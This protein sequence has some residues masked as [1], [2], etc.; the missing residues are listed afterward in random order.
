M[1]QSMR[2]IPSTF[3][4]QILQKAR[5]KRFHL[6]SCKLESHASL[7]PQSKWGKRWQLLLLLLWLLLDL[8]ALP[9]SFVE[10]EVCA[11]QKKEWTKKYAWKFV[12]LAAKF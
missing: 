6:H 1:K 11:A 9:H 5:H 12:A 4:L 10:H 2:I 8:A 3:D 7:P